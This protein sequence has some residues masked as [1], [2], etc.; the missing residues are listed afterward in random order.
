MQMNTDMLSEIFEDNIESLGKLDKKSTV[1]SD[2]FYILKNLRDESLSL[3]VFQFSKLASYLEKEGEYLPENFKK[4]F[5]RESL[6]HFF[7][8]WMGF[9]NLNLKNDFNA[10]NDEYM[11]NLSKDLISFFN[12][13][14]ICNDP[15][16]KKILMITV[17]YST[18]KKIPI[19]PLNIP[20]PAGKKIYEKDGSYY[21]PV[22]AK[23]QDDPFA[24]C[25]FCIA[26]PE[27]E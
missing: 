16:L 26:K 10:L 23:H 9:R 6:N 8:C 4:N 5:I 20:F 27:D 19:H 22:K 1:E 3:D 15:V 25:R 7:R 11:E 13:T 12:K 24:L 21:C 17:F 14:G 18:I 2:L